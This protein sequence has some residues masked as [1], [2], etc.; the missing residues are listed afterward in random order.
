MSPEITI[1]EQ[2][3]A[4]IFDCDCTLVDSMPRHM[5]AWQQAFALI[6]AD[7]D[8]DL[9]F[10]FRGMKEKDVIESYNRH[11]KAGLDPKEMVRIKHQFLSKKFMM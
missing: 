8:R 1:P 2:I 11:Y 4:L 10:S 3:K 9:L 6:G 7:Y 5:E